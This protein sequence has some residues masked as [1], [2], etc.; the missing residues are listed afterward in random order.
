MD[1]DLR[2]GRVRGER[3]GWDLGGQNGLDEYMDE[4]YLCCQFLMA[5]MAD[6]RKIKKSLLH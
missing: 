6:L 4:Y 3:A 5:F 2:D 1:P